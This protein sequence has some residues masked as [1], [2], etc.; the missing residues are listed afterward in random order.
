[1]TSAKA[2]D[3][4]LTG[5]FFKYSI[6]SPFGL[7]K[8]VKRE[9][10][11]LLL[12]SR[13]IGCYNQKANTFWQL[14]HSNLDLKT[15]NTSD[16]E[17]IKGIGL[18]TSRC[19]LIHSRKNAKCAG[20][21]THVLKYLRSLGVDAPKSTPSKRKY[22]ELEDIFVGL[23]EDSGKGIAE[24]D[25][26]LWKMYSGNYNENKEDLLNNL[27]LLNIDKACQ[28]KLFLLNHK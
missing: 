13:G 24:F 23:A 16:L 26:L 12:K 7:I 5:L 28:E 1:M 11:P 10:L 21:D 14:V 3:A 27:T 15:C 9:D 4:L 25:L 2:L 6:S 19:F 18:K 8:K 20:L 22:L 17:T